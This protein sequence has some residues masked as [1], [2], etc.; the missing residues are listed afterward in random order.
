MLVP[1]TRDFF[2]AGV[3]YVEVPSPCQFSFW[4]HLQWLGSIWKHSN[5]KYCSGHLESFI[6]KN[7]NSIWKSTWNNLEVQE[8]K[9]SLFYWEIIICWLDLALKEVCYSSFYY[10]VVKCYFWYFYIK[11]DFNFNKTSFWQSIYILYIKTWKVL[12]RMYDFKR[13]TCCC[14]RSCRRKLYNIYFFRYQMGFFSI[15]YQMGFS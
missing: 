12:W 3:P 9:H 11:I 7:I 15:R 1:I 13:T 10:A 4:S 2:K 6:R 8:I 5:S 14:V